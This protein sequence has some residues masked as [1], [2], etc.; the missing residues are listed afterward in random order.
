MLVFILQEPLVSDEFLAYLL[1]PMSQDQWDELSSSAILGSSPA[2]HDSSIQWRSPHEVSHQASPTR[3]YVSVV[4]SSSET[5]NTSQIDRILSTLEDLTDESAINISPPGTELSASELRQLFLA[6]SSTSAVS[7]SA[8]DAEVSSI[9]TASN[10]ASLSVIEMSPKPAANA[11]HP[12]GHNGTL[13]PG[14]SSISKPEA[15]RESRKMADNHQMNP[16]PSSR[17]PA[18]DSW[19]PTHITFCQPP[20]C[21]R[22]RKATG[23]IDDPPRKRQKS[24]MQS[25]TNP[26]SYGDTTALGVSPAHRPEVSNYYQAVWTIPSGERDAVSPTRRE[27]GTSNLRNNEIPLG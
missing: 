21:V 5:S 11:E 15:K 23:S 22:R 9:S 6:I 25:Y 3:S 2:Q 24:S 4:S 19:L 20:A 18:S 27:W 16:K 17:K 12:S 1:S 13:P 14:P 10:S 26:A 7:I 8:S